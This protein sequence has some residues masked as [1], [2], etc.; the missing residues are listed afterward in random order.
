M[1]DDVSL[2]ALGAFLFKSAA[3][4]SQ[5]L[6]THQTNAG[7]SGG[8]ERADKDESDNSSNPQMGSGSVDPYRCISN[9][10]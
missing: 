10:L 4:V 6:P 3:S 5:V 7:W 9:I 1:H 2:A 8:R